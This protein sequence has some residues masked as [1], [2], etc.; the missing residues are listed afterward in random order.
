[1]IHVVF[2]LSC[3]SQDQDSGSCHPLLSSKGILPAPMGIISVCI[4]GSAE[5]KREILA[6]RDR[7]SWWSNSPGWEYQLGFHLSR[8]R[9][10]QRHPIPYPP[11]EH[12][13]VQVR[14]ISGSCLTVEGAWIKGFCSFVNLG[15][16]RGE[17][18]WV[19][20]TVANRASRLFP[21]PS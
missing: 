1:M 3:P 15:L 10:T 5:L 19:Q 7:S 14:W 9:H 4:Q 16:E 11:M 13:L 8:Q 17:G 18:D 20:V 2:S 12:A 21:P 6:A